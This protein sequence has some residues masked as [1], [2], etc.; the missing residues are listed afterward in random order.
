MTQWEETGMQHQ[1]IQIDIL[2]E[3]GLK[4]MVANQLMQGIGRKT[5]QVLPAVENGFTE[6]AINCLFTQVFI[7]RCGDHYDSIWFY[8]APQLVK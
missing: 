6:W 8:Q 5:V 4:T 3:F 1:L 2:A 7:V